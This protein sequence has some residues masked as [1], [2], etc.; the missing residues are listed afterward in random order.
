MVCVCSSVLDLVAKSL[1]ILRACTDSPEPLLVAK[2]I[3]TEISYAGSVV[4]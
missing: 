1:A 4:M 3:S 2:E